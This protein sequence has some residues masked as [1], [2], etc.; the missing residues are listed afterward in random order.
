VLFRSFSEHPPDGPCVG[1]RFTV[2]VVNA[3]MQLPQWN[4]MAIIVTW[5]DWGGFYDHVKPPVRTSRNGARFGSGFRLP[6]LIISPYAKKGLVL[7]TPTEQASVP[8]LVEELWQMPF[9][10][11]RNAHARDGVA[12]SLKDA[13]DFDQTP[14][15][16]VIL[17]RGSCPSDP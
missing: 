8:K 5:D 3:A 7:K 17:K 11:R 1:E 15:P 16:P 6:L 13:F 10:S 12:G 14:R 4:Q 2:D 9:M